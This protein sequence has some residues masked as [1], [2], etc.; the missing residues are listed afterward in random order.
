[1]SDFLKIRL[2]MTV[3][4]LKAACKVFL[5]HCMENTRHVA[6]SIWI[7]SP[8]KAFS[9]RVSRKKCL[10]KRSCGYSGGSWTTTSL[11]VIN[12]FADWANSNPLEGCSLCDIERGLCQQIW[13]IQSSSTVHCKQ[14]TLFRRNNRCFFFLI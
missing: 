6:L 2:T 9:E 11:Q 10:A 8:F 13:I 5:R 12:W 1:M 3:Q 7:P 14:Q 4:Y